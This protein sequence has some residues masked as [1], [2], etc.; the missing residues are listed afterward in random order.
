MAATKSI[1]V[2]GVGRRK[3]ATA[4]VRLTP[5]A[6]TEITVNGKSNT[7]PESYNHLDIWNKVLQFRKYYYKKYAK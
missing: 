2:E 6:K 7:S 4:R 1:Y 3:T 5:A